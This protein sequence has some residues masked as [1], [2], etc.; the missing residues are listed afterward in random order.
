L[1]G[2][3][4][5]LE[6]GWTTGKSGSTGYQNKRLRSINANPQMTLSVN[7]I[8]REALTR[9]QWEIDQIMV[10]RAVVATDLSLNDMI[11]LSTPGIRARPSRF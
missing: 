2:L 6:R 10:G 4:A 9:L 3:L 11:Q 8:G 7:D 5:G 1:A